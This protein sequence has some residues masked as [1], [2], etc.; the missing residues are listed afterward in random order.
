MVV[1]RRLAGVDPGWAL[2]QIAF[3]LERT[4]APTY[5][6]RAFRRAAEVVAGLSA[7]ELAGRIRDGTLRELAGI[8][9]VTAQ[10]IA[11]AAAGQEPDCG[12]GRP[13]A[14]AVAHSLQEGPWPAPAPSPLNDHGG[15]CPGKFGCSA[16]V[17][18]PRLPRWP[19]PGV[20]PRRG[21]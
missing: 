19:G 9:E 2:R 21:M 10:V 12:R 8:G 3:Q 16:L 11:Q 15:R 17:T 13:A 1:V 4:G 7:G 20:I 5:R 6:V 14:H 18:T